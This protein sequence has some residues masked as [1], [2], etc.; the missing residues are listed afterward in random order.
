MGE[1]LGIGITHYP[2]LL[3]SPDEF[4]N[5]LR[6]VL[7]SPVIPDEVKD[8]KSWPAAMQDEYEHEHE[9]AVVHQEQCRKAFLRVRKAIDDFNPDAV[10]IF[11][12][13]QYEN[14]KEDGLPPFNVYA[15]D[16]FHSQPFH[17]RKSNS[18]W[19]DPPDATVHHRGHKEL[20]RH[21]A[22]ELIERDMPVSFSLTNRHFKYGLTHA[23]ANALLYLD[24]ERKGF[25]YPVVPIQVNCYGKDVIS[26]QGLFANLFPGS[27]PSPFANEEAVPGPSPRSCFRLGKLVREILEERP[28]RVALIASSSWSHAFLTSKNNWLWPDVE[29]DR[30]L[31]EQLRRGEHGQWANLSNADIDDSGEQEFKNWICLAGAMEDRQPEVL[32]FLESYTFNSDK[33]FALFKP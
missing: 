5:I 18:I 16:E 21:I 23:F 25:P 1:I 31:V 4:A 10:V 20:A 19:D 33:C 7:K 29:M 27:N 28:E 22:T 24:W 30:Q 17:N 13:D 3:G 9:R 11:G 12:D 8:P 2:P 32:D 14:F 26:T 15:I 6:A